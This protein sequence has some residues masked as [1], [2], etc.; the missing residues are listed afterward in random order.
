VYGLPR[1]LFEDGLAEWAERRGVLVKAIEDTALGVASVYRSLELPLPKQLPYASKELRS[2]WADLL[3]RIMPFDLVI[4]EHTADGQE[5]RVSKTSVA[6]SWGAV[7]G[8]L[9]F[10]ADRFGVP[11]AGI[12]GTTLSYDLVRQYA[13]PGPPRVVLNGQRKHLGLSLER[14]RT[15]FGFHLDTQVEPI[16]GAIPEPLRPAA[17]DVLT[18][19]LL[20]GETTHPDQQRLRRALQEV[21]EL[22]RRSGGTLPAVAPSALRQRIRAQL[23]SLDSWEQFLRTRIA[24]D[25]ADLVPA[26]I[27]ERLVALPSSLRLRGDAVP[28]DYEVVDGEGIARVRLREGQ[29]KRLRPDELPSLDRPLR[30][31]VQRGRH[32]PLLADTLPALQ[33]L[34]RRAPKAERSE[35]ERARRGPSGSRRHSPGPKRR[36]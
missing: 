20:T 3:A 21:D 7:A 27:R 6:G 8:N 14:R 29:A 23:E 34:L 19:A 30:F 17:R 1:H 33:A 16:T 12:E 2:L 26:E 4:D 25:P 15:Y 11:R 32:A 31:A 10:F 36:R 28:L 24:L 5:A 9:R 22:W 18:E 13:A 35:D